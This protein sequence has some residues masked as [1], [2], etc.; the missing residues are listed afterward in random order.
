MNNDFINHDRRW[1]DN[2]EITAETAI[3]LSKND[4]RSTWNKLIRQFLHNDE[5]G[6]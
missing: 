2:N 3:N 5:K 4:K 1:K 6:I